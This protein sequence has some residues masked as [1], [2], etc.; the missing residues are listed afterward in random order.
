MSR[1][2]YTW[3]HRPG[4]QFGKVL[5][6]LRALVQRLA[7][8]AAAGRY[9]TVLVTREA[10]P[11]G[12]AFIETMLRPRGP[13]IAF[14]FD[15]AIWI[16]NYSAANPLARWLK[17][18]EKTALILRLSDVA[19]AGNAYLAAYAA[20]YCRSV[21]VIP[22]TIDTDAYVPGPRRDG[23]R[24][25]IGWTGSTTTQGYLD[26]V[27]E[28]LRHLQRERGARVVTVGAPDWSPAGLDVERHPWSPETEVGLLQTFDIGLMPL[29]RDPWSEGKC[30][31]KA[32][33]YM[34]LG[35]P[36]VVSPV[37]VNTQIVEHWRTGVHAEGPDAWH[38]ALLRL[39]DDAALRR[40]LGDRA[41][42]VVEERYS[43]RANAS[44]WLKALSGRGRDGAA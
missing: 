19:I 18:P 7:D 42:V 26:L 20:R 5:V 40:R 29:T 30:G 14:D 38:E 23:G 4:R 21:V 16:P 27:V 17:R 10:Y 25:V 39:H 41:R 35:V 11:I 1:D 24:V 32:L 34:A 8:V 43:V 2:A 3:F 37:G 22:T 12:P 6:M 33:Q 13:R 28:P 9:D 31:L 15:D 36:A 44:A